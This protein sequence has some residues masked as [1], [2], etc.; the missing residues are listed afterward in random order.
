[1]KPNQAKLLLMGAL[2]LSA[3]AGNSRE[4]TNP[5]E[6]YGISPEIECANLSNS[7]TEV[8]LYKYN[9]FRGTEFQEEKDIFI[10]GLTVFEKDSRAEEDLIEA[11]WLKISPT[12]NGAYFFV[13]DSTNSWSFSEELDLTGSYISTRIIFQ[14]TVDGISA[15]VIAEPSENMD[16]I[17]LSF[18]KT[19][20]DKKI[21]F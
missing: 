7:D 1:M 18:I 19:G 5:K 10:N 12:R 20:C 6:Y 21:E 3:C 13:K 2:F 4:S 9:L 17:T 14:T 16:G 8:Q 11:A 15:E